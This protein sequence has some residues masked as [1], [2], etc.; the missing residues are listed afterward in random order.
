VQRG[1]L[2]GEFDRGTGRELFAHIPRAMLAHTRDLVSQE[3]GYGIDGPLTVDDV[4]IDPV[5]AGTPSTGERQWRSVIIGSYREGGRGLYALDLTQPDP[6]APRTVL[7]FAGRSGVEYV[8]VAPAQEVPTCSALDRSPPP[9]CGLPYP[10]VL[11]EFGDECTFVN[12]VTGRSL[13]APCDEDTNGYPDLAFS[14]SKVNTGRVLVT[15]AG[16]P[17]PVVKFVALFG[18]GI[19]P[20][21]RGLSGNFLYMVDIETGKVLYKTELSGAVPS[22]PAAV[23][24]DANGI[25]DTVYIGTTA[26]LLYKVD[27][28]QP[29]ALGASSGQVDESLHWTPFPIFDTGGREIFFRPTVF[30]DSSSGHYALAFGTG[31]REDLWSEAGGGEEGRFYVILDPGFA[32]GI[33]PIASGPLTESSYQQIPVA[34]DPSIGNFLVA[35]VSGNQPGWV[36]QLGDDE[37]VVTDA[38]AISGLLAFTTFDP[39]RPD[40]CT[41]GGNG[42]VYTL[43]AT[44]ANA[45]GGEAERGIPIEGFAGKPVVTPQGF[46][47]QTGPGT[48]ADPFE[49]AQPQSVRQSLTG[50]FP[51]E[52]RF[53]NFSLNV[54]S[55][56]SSSE[57]MPLAQIPV[58][59]A[60]QNWTEP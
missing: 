9:G 31:D 20:R 19:D 30:Y 32:G 14:W 52:C 51:A 12:D 27:I 35:P 44:N 18:G 22:E 45:V 43:L 28:A 54:S 41:F 6:V 34:S 39:D 25:L 47:R 11:W 40:L 50:L 56:L 26:G 55:S 46:S 3:H 24:T 38:L 42:S 57:V 1:H 33:A 58:C 7:D 21:H 53:G 23:D 8:P 48:T 36:L 37:R 16:E 59:V 4:F 29:A 49:A 60:R 2:I 5:H 17:D 13:L 10:S 15:P